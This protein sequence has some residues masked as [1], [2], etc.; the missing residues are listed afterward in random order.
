MGLGWNAAA[1]ASHLAMILAAGMLAYRLAVVRR[2]PNIAARLW[3]DEPAQWAVWALAT[4]FLIERGYYVIARWAIMHGVDFWKSHPV[5]EGLALMLVAALINL[6]WRI[7]RVAA[8][9]RSLRWQWADATVICAV[10]G[11]VVLTTW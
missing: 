5:P 11:W 9:G 4:S 7:E 10:W 2:V 1:L 8:S 6:A 3:A